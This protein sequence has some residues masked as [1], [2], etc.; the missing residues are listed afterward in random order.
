MMRGHAVT[1]LHV[2][3]AD[4]RATTLDAGSTASGRPAGTA[5]FATWIAMATTP[6][7]Q[8]Y[9]EAEH[10]PIAGSSA[11]ARASEPHLDWCLDADTRDHVIA[12]RNV[13]TGLWAGRRLG[14]TG[15]ELTRYAAGMHRA[16]YDVPG[17]ADIVAVLM[18]D[19]AAAGMVMLEGDL[20][21]TIAAFHRQALVE[22]LCTD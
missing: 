11:V 19:F 3:A 22:T 15:A 17:D 14:M 21:Q 20:R 9:R 4:H 1:N 7:R 16:D 6:T 18:Q 10:S 2:S 13:L 5:R 8:P 12:R